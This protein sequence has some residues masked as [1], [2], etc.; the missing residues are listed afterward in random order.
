MTEPPDDSRANPEQRLTSFELF[1]LALSVFAVSNL[2]W[3]I[4]PCRQV[5]TNV[6]LI[7]DRVL[8]AIFLADFLLRLRRAP[9][10]RDYFFHGGGWTDLISCIPYPIFM[11]ARIPRIVQVWRPARAMGG[12]KVFK[13]LMEN[14]ASSALLIAIFLVIVVLQYGAM[15]M[16]TA[17]ARDPGANIQNGSDAVWW[18]YVSITT[19]GYGDRYPVTNSGRLV[20]I[21]VLATG[22]GLF[23]VITGFLADTFRAPRRAKRDEADL[24]GQITEL[25]ATVAAL[26]EKLDRMPKE[27]I[28]SDEIM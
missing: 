13:R 4:I 16:L 7:I 17:E 20:G 21:V 10:N 24:A 25:T 2:I 28:R 19:V 23:G 6:V 11:L 22:M 12:P 14:L 3:F 18:A 1:V 15:L 9:R 8:S 26:S 5:I 27:S